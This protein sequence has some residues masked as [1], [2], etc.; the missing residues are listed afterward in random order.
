MLILESNPFRYGSFGRPVYIGL[1]GIYFLM[2]RQIPGRILSMQIAL[3]SF[4]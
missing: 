3:S 2:S 1:F 4:H